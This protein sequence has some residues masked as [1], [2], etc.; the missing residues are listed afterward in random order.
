MSLLSEDLF[1]LYFYYPFQFSFPI[2]V[3]ISNLAL[4]YENKSL[5]ISTV[6]LLVPPFLELVTLCNA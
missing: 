6:Y 5:Y 2:F 3:Y 1:W 4:D